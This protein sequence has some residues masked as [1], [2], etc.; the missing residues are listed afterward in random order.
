MTVETLSG[1]HLT[2]LYR[3]EY[4]MIVNM[5]SHMFSL[6]QVEREKIRGD[7]KSHIVVKLPYLAKCRNPG[8]T[9]L[10]HMVGFYAACGKS[11]QNNSPCSQEESLNRTLNGINAFDCGDPSIIRS[12]MTLLKILIVTDLRKR[13]NPDRFAPHRL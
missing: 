2:D 3:N 9:A 6:N 4:E 11:T 8:E 7:V 5:V 12:G 1:K 10:S 13:T